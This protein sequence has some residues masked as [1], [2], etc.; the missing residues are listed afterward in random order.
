MGDR[1]KYLQFSGREEDYPFWS[2]KFEAAMAARGSEYEAVLLGTNDPPSEER[3]RVLLAA[4]K[5]TIWVDLVQVLDR[6][7]LMLVRRDCKGDGRA[8]WL[9]IAEHFKST[10]RPRVLT[11]M[12]RLTNLKLEETEDVG[13]YLIRAEEIEA[14]LHDAGEEITKSMMFSLVLKGLPS[15]YE[16]FVT[17]QNM[18]KGDIDYPGMKKAL[19]NFSNTR[20]ASEPQGS[21]AFS[22]AMSK[23]KCYGCGE[24]GHKKPA[25]PKS[26]KKGAKG[27][28]FK[29]GKEGHQ[30][31][32]CSQGESRDKSKLQCHG[33][34]G[35][36][37]FKAECPGKASEGNLAFGW[38]P[39]GGDFA[40][41]V[42]SE[43]PVGSEFLV[44]DS[45][46]TNHMINKRCLFQS[47]VP[48]QG[49]FVLNANKA[50]TEVK[51]L[52][53]AVVCVQDAE[54]RR[55]RMLLHNARFVPDFQRSLL[56][57]SRIVGWRGG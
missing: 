32:S 17:V 9:M 14:D 41:S 7:T 56:S 37:H 28:C 36:G 48:A 4:V 47:L 42:G 19:V 25:C 12:S 18:Q 39:P 20:K 43:L 13:D 15:E 57:V 5:K 38:G 53:T 8:A 33:C 44:V 35:F 24:P 23:I 21:A 30:A 11:L 40:F 51:G 16:T 27:A 50:R 6:K 34:K 52:G 55:C 31:K 54:G 2:E 22:A 29:C 3:H 26:K 49:E 46:C 45:G 10:E 1:L